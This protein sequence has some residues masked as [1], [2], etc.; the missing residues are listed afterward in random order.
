M[1]FM[2]PINLVGAALKKAFPAL[3]MK[4]CEEIALAYAYSVYADKSQSLTD[5]DIVRIKWI[6]GTHIATTHDLA[7]ESVVSVLDEH[8]T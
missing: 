6:I 1:P 2:T 3:P 4:V 8:L 5:L 7:R